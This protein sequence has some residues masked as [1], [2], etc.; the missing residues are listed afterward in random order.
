MSKIELKK[1]RENKKLTQEVVAEKMHIPITTIRK[2]EKGDSIPAY[3]DMKALAIILGVD[4][5]EVINACAPKVTKVCSAQEY[6]NELAGRLEEIFWGSSDIN[7]FF[8]IS[9]IFSIGSG[10]GVVLYDD[11]AFPFSRVMSGELGESTCLILS[12][13][14]RNRIVLTRKNIID[15]K[16]LKAIYDVF[17]FE[18]TVNCPLFPVDEKYDPAQFEQVIKLYF[19]NAE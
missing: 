15:V 8:L 12:D 18:I 4:E 14:N 10:R 6:E 13:R 2:W 5:K 17:S 16:P 9:S 3:Q 11:N 19:F 7:V 1:L